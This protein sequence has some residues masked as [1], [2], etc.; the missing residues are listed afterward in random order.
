[1]T[2]PSSLF[3]HGLGP[4]AR[5]PE[6]Q[7]ATDLLRHAPAQAR[8]AVYTR[9]E[10]VA[11]MLDLAGYLP[12]QDLSGT[13]LLEPCFG[14]GV[15]LLQAVRRRLDAYFAFGGTSG[16]AVDD[17]RDAVL[18]A[19]IHGASTATTR[20]HLL[21]LLRSYGLTSVQAE[22]L[23][24]QWLRQDDFLLMD[25]PG[26]FSHVLGNPPYLRSEEISPALLGAYRQRYRTVADRAD[27]FVPF[28]ERG[29]DLLRPG[30][31]LC[32]VCSDR[33]LRNVYGRLLRRKVD[34]GFHLAAHLD[35]GGTPVFDSAVTAYPAVTLL[36]RDAPA[37]FAPLPAR[38]TFLRRP[39]P[40]DLSTLAEAPGRVDLVGALHG[41][42]PHPDVIGV[43]VAV[44][45]EDPWLLDLGPSLL[46][47]RGIEA[48]FPSL[49]HAGV[50]VGI[51]LATGLDAVFTGPLDAFEIEADRL[52]PLVMAADVRSG[53]L[54]WSGLGAVNPYG[55]DG[56]LVSL[57]AYPR[58]A[59]YLQSFS[60]AVRGRDAA[61]RSPASWYRTQSRPLPGLLG[62][63]K[64]LM[65]DLNARVAVAYDAGGF[66]PHHNVYHLTSRT[67]PL[68]ALQTVLRSTVTLLFMR[69]YAVTMRGG[70]L[71]TQ[72]GTLRRLRLPAWRDLPVPLR[73][74]L[75]SLAESPDLG[76]VDH[77]AA[78]VYGLTPAEIRLL[79][80]RSS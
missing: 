10:L 40:L 23:S 79:P 72:A 62:T 22:A 52:L 43:P 69:G 9:P 36:V 7:A 77:A 57:S 2:G 24:G 46:V 28:F 12:E 11:L 53:T 61:R 30:G 65:P 3:E 6:V 21:T 33:W 75:I 66:Y 73:R 51:G 34:A 15:F 55:D 49:S 78:Q 68:R 17:L 31:K 71:R 60:D 41:T 44:Q 32:F 45:G 70:T 42:G 64:L 8:G 1:M 56:R 59:A 19:E 58:L 80:E 50:R 18:A 35:L 47:L 76:A 63:P 39:A 37:A 14:A 54:R 5:S 74:T 27:L 67:W 4:V 25:V 13:R 16:R 20:Q 38:V 48:R 26:S 29:L